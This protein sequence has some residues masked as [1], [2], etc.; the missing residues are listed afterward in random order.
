[1]TRATQVWIVLLRGVNVGGNNK[2]PM[3]QFAALLETL[4]FTDIKTYIQSGNAV[5]RGPK[6][7][8]AALADAIASAIEETFD[9]R[10][11]V[12]VLT[13]DDL[14]K[15]IAANPFPEGDDGDGRTLHLFFLGETPKKIDAASLDAVKRPTEH[16]KTI[17]PFLYFHAPE[18]FGTSKLAAKLSSKA[19]KCLG[20]PATARNWRTVRELLKL[21]EAID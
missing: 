16:W 3:K 13:K 11:S 12:V 9:F 5:F 21:A 7:P 4:G 17:G 1:M 6:G 14:A 19:E 18:G 10:P 2:L 8:P 20:V 15:A